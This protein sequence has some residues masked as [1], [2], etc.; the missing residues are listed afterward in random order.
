MINSDLEI[1]CYDITTRGV[2]PP[3]QSMAKTATHVHQTVAGKNGPPRIAFPNPEGDG[4]V[5]RS[6][7]CLEG[8]FT[9]GLKGEDGQDTGTGFTLKSIEDDP[10]GFSAD[11]H[12]S[13]YVP[14]AVRGQL[15]SMPVGG[16]ETGL[17][18]GE[19]ESGAI[20]V[21]AAAVFATVAAVLVS[22]RRVRA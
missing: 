11:T 17:G 2:T 9:T 13:R 15:T 1:I 19:S 3:Y 8:P 5:R 18:G 20:G 14:G 22:R 4:D 7:G 12:T 21:A 10:S 6:T 16:V